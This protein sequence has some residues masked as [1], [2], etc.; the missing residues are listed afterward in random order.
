M[1]NN[2]ALQQMPHFSVWIFGCLNRRMLK[3]IIYIYD[4]IHV[5]HLA[6]VHRLG[7]CQYLLPTLQ[8]V[9]VASYNKKCGK[10]D[11]YKLYIT[12]H[13]CNCTC[14]KC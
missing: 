5:P 13:T 10:Q 12:S 11:G 6:V 4:C 14:A 9:V 2:R 3:I 8:F 1:L 7:Y